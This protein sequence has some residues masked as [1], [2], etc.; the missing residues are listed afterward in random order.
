MRCQLYLGERK[1]VQLGIKG[2]GSVVRKEKGGAHQ[3]GTALQKYKEMDYARK[4]QWFGGK[5]GV[6]VG[7]RR[8]GG[9]PQKRK[10]V[11]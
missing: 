11:L 2:V 1:G 9:E 5:R 3:G 8:R 7:G 6:L 4:I 10:F